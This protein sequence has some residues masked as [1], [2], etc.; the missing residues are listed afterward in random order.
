MAAFKCSV[1][2]SSGELDQAFLR[3]SFAREIPCPVC[4]AK[5]HAKILPKVL[6]TCAPFSA[7][8]FAIYKF[9]P[10]ISIWINVPLSAFVAL[11]ALMLAQ[12][13]ANFTNV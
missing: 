9:G 8:H 4:L 1:C 3:V 5:L 13:F 12:R 10:P 2:G 11:I 6:L 7:Y